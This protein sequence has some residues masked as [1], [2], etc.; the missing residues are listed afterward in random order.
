MNRSIRLSI[1]IGLIAA[2]LFVPFIGKLH[3]FDWD[4]INFAESAREMLQT[5]DYLNVQIFYESFW[6]KPPL[7]IWFQAISMKLF[8]VN[9]FAARFPNAVA[10]I[11]TL[12]VLFNFGKKLKNERF[13][14]IWATAYAASILPFFYFKS[15]IIDPWFNLFI[16]LGIAEYIYAQ[17]ESDNKNKYRY[18]ILSAI[19]IGLA[20]LTKGPVALVIFGLTAIGLLFRE[21]FTLHLKF[22]H[23]V[24]FILIFVIT[25]GF[26]FILQI[27]NGNWQ[28][29]VD[30]I[31]YQIRLFSIEDS[32]HGGFPLYHFVVL[33]FGV[34]PISLFAIHGHKKSKVYRADVDYF[35]TSMVFSFWIVLI[36]FS[37]VKTKIVHYSS[38]CYFPMSFLAAYSVYG[39]IK[40]NNRL[41]RWLSVGQLFLT[42]LIGILV[43]MAP[44]FDKNKGWFIE[45]FNITHS[46][47]VGNLQGDPGWTG[48]ESAIGILLI[49]G[50]IVSVLRIKNGK[51]L[52]GFKL[53]GITS[54][55]FI[56]AIMIFIVPGAEKYSQNAAIE[57][58]K[59]QKD[60]DVYVQT[61]YKSYAKHFYPQINE[62]EEDHP[63]TQIW[64]EKRKNVAEK[65]IDTK[66]IYFTQWL[67]EGDIDKTAYFVVRIDKKEQTLNRF[68]K[69]KVLYE[70][71]G[72]VF[73]IREPEVKDEQ[74]DQQQ[75]DSNSTTGI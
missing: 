27:L 42:A 10:G 63:F 52:R 19:F 7:F 72:Y 56:Y 1:W 28:T 25:G 26:W 24:A 20:V 40:Q 64:N 17:L 39:I 44:V 58:F 74:N 53:M 59:S 3:L 11:V 45:K 67:A 69:V 38:F 62:F 8:G 61:F 46:F 9:E 18:I 65:I 54:V 5:K 75:E 12:M 71:N 68:K 50:M 30:F 22:S 41:P 57:F 23:V 32:G 33:L 13:G 4:E 15:G 2:L 51:P 35:R 55:L 36:L 70:K 66:E 48:M 49:I 16:F 34:F 31:V 73:C 60:K 14:V 29:V 43:A 37:I 21:R 6:E 47:T